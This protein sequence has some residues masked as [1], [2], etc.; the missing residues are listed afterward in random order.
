[1]L[2]MQVSMLLG[3]IATLAFVILNSKK[4]NLNIKYTIVWISWA[5]IMIILSLNPK[6]IDYAARILHIHTPVNALFL[7]LILFVYLICFYVFIRM[8]EMNE[9]IKTLTYEISKMKKESEGQ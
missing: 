1:M 8:S 6:I 2:K 5:I 7:V 4:H 3:S 9:K